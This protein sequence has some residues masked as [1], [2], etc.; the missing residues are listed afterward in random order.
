MVIYTDNVKKGGLV[1]AGLLTLAGAV[2]G[3]K[4]Y[5]LPRFKKAPSDEPSPPPTD[6]T[7]TPVDNDKTE[8]SK[9]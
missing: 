4:T 9:K 3:V 7:T 5:V 8:N 2:Y 6:K 1:V